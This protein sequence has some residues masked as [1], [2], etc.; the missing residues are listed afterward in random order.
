M[1]R[2]LSILVCIGLIVTLG[3]SLSYGQGIHAHFENE[4]KK[5]TNTLSHFLMKGRFYGHARS[6]WSVTDNQG[7]LTDAYAWGL[8]AGI[9]YETP[10]IWK[11]IQ[12][13]MSGFFMFNVASSDL[14]KRD[15]ITN[16]TN[17]YEVG[18][19]DMLQPEDHEDLDRLE[20]LYAKI[21]ISPKTML[22]VGRQ[23]PQT[24]FINPQDG[25][26]RPT[27]TESVVLNT[28]EWEHLSLH[29]EYIWRIS[30]RSTV[31]WFG[32]GESIGIYPVGQS[33]Q[34]TPSQYAEHV[35][36]RGIGVVGAT[37]QK[38]NWTV[39]LWDMYTDNIHNTAMLK[40]EWKSVP[41][42]KRNWMI[43]AQLIRQQAVG[44]GG[45]HDPAKR[46]IEPNNHSTVLSVRAGRQTPRFDWYVNAT[47]ISAEGRYL[48]PREW[49]RET[50]Y[51]FLP[52]ERNEGAGDVTATTINTFYRPQ[53]NLKIELSGGYY[54]LPDVQNHALNKYGMPSYSQVNLGV[55]YQFEHYLKGLNAL[56][57]VVR[58][59]RIGDTYE[60]ERFIYNKVN[61]T[62]F[63][64]ILNYYF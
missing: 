34:G 48:M 51:T 18:L 17:R 24:P 1:L 59:D 2:Q 56:L 53:S 9:G 29:A 64:L 4:A 28:G 42:G 36:S 32:V 19:F 15:P 40:A 14:A 20:E 25:R 30:P 39:Q 50:F 43:G 54:H 61:M 27:L 13:G 23:V 44:E 5:D 57:L 31:E 7:D 58:K 37:F 21:H 49:G 41:T 60:N 33:P 52:R 62:H 22:S 12:L 47:R 11:R 63:N 16:Q 55:T 38:H 45:S 8:G 26:M 10:K 6:Y 35:E 46:Y 3:R